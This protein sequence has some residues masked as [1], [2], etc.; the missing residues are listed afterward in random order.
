MII[1]HKVRTEV[2]VKVSYYSPA[3]CNDD[4]GGDHFGTSNVGGDHF[5]TMTSEVTTSGD[6]A[7]T[8]SPIKIIAPAMTISAIAFLN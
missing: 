2:A 1:E 4:V 3:G 5:G 7:V 6:A 8:I